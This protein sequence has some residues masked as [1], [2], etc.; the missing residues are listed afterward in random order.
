VRVHHLN[1]LTMCP[2]GGRLINGGNAALST[3]GEMCA[4]ALVVETKAGL[5]LVDTGIG[6]DD[7]RDARARLGRGFLAFARPRLREEHT[8]ARQIESLGYARRDVRHVVLTHLDVDHAGGIP[9]FPDAQI[10]V[11]RREHDAAMK[12][13]TRL[14]RERYRKVHFAHKPKWTLH[15]VDGE[16]WLGFQS[17][18]A[19]TDEV[20]LI[21][22]FGHTR[23]HCG[24]AVRAPE[25][26]G[27]EWFLHCG[28][29]YFNHGQLEDPPWCPGGLA[30][31]Q[32]I[33]AMDNR[34]RIENTGRLRELH[35]NHATRVRAFS[36]HD[37]DELRAITAASARAAQE[38]SEDREGDLERS[39]VTADAASVDDDRV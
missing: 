21:P 38:R 5:V 3:P 13:D 2:F 27:V 11:H 24:V 17:V 30:A 36:A 6:L 12:R 34:S 14:E 28:D 25:E 31:F 18:R 26:S 19:V 29:A 20:L 16:K 22:L 10:H 4:H 39:L 9:D 33:A 23:G 7:V 15:E 37:P 35:K 8:A 1:L 32:R